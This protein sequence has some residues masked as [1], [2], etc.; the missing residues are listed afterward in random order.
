MRQRVALA[1]CLAQD[2]RIVL[3]DEPL[4]ALD[5]M[6]RD[7]LHD[8]IERVVRE[9]AL[10]VIL[11]THNMREA[12]RL[13][14]RVVLMAAG[15]SS[16][17]RSSTFPT[18]GIWT[19]PRSPPAPP[20]SPHDSARPREGDPWH[21]ASSNCA[22]TARSPPPHPACARHPALAVGLD[23]AK[24]LAVLLVLA[25]WQ[26][27]VWSGWRPQYALASPAETL[28][29]LWEMLG[30]ERFWSAVATTLRRAVVGFAVS[31]VIGTAV[32]SRSR[33]CA[34]CGWPSAR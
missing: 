7:H 13:A 12:V 18:P 26:V 28:S 29:R 16:T 24:A 2:A 1:R 15:G 8:E 9:R 19:P 34:R 4:G 17:N 14:D 10:T 22:T 27:V 20:T 3:M 32:A 31:L 21:G 33:R 5:A 23:L 11:V 30:T 25:T 6:T